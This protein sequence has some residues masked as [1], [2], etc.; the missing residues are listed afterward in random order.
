MRERNIDTRPFFWPLSHLPA[1]AETEE[2]IKA[3]RRNKVAYALTKSGVN[4][5]SGMRLTEADVDRVCRELL[6]V[7]GLA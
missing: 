4:L 5:P 3:A 7:T 6:D 1:Y 2:G